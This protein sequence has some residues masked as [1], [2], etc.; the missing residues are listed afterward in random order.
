MFFAEVREVD[1]SSDYMLYD[2]CSLVKGLII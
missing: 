1:V 2:N